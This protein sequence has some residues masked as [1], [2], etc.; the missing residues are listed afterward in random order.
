MCSFC[1]LLIVFA[2]RLFDLL[3]LIFSI[4][5]HCFPV[6][7]IIF[8]SRKYSKVI[9]KIYIWKEAAHLNGDTYKGVAHDV[10]SLYKSS[11][12]KNVGQVLAEADPVNILEES[13]PEEGE[14]VYIVKTEDS[15]EALVFKSLEAEE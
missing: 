6:I 12:E 7:V 5:I 10:A 14:E 8:F 4:Q 3:F 11:E 9:C 13:P 1:N 15:D 2:W